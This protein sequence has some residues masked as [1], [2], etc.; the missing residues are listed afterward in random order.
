M[1][2]GAKKSLHETMPTWCCDGQKVMAYGDIAR[3]SPASLGSRG[4]G[5]GLWGHGKVVVY[6]EPLCRSLG[7]KVI[8]YGE[9]L[10]NPHPE[11]H[12]LWGRAI[13]QKVMVCG[14][15]QIRSC[16]YS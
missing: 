8:L 7:A 5:H 13:S 9:Q 15:V 2:Y 11:G 6:G 12:G 10:S 1:L 3:G 4:K 16:G 14:E